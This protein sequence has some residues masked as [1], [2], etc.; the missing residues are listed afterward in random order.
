MKNNKG[1]TLSSLTIYVIV[2]IVILVVLTFVSA[3]FTS[4]IS[5]VTARGNI[6]NESLKLYSFLIS[7]LKSANAVVEYAD[8]FVRLDNDVKYSIKYISNRATEKM[9]YEI[10]RNDVLISENILDANF[11][12]DNTADALLVN[13]KYIYGKTVI[14]KAQTFKIGRGYWGDK[15][16]NQRGSVT[17]IA[18]FTMLIFSLYG[19][20]LYGR[21]ASS[22]I[23]QSSSIETIQN[24]Y[25]ADVEHAAQIAEM[26][27][28]TY[29]TND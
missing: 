28:A 21:S 23:R 2:L 13:L 29:H 12:Y 8:D 26:L 24:A 22:Y 25:S 1:V 7:D 11:N 27:G 20:L 10:Y 16:K 14:E 9:Q 15:M 19:I 3:N 4:Q 18:F 5:D 6:S 17:M